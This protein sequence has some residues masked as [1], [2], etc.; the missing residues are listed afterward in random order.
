VKILLVD[1]DA[2]TLDV[3]TYSLRKNGYDVVTSTDGQQAIARWDR[4]KPDLVVL[5]VNLPK[6]N[7]FEVCRKIR[8][9]ALTPV[10]MLTGRTD[11]E[12]VL[13]GFTVGADD[14]VT[15]PFSHRQLVARIR[16]VM[17]RVGERVP[18]EPAGQVKTTDMV[19]DLQ[20]HEVIRNGQAVRL[21]PLEFKMLYMLASN[22]GRVVSSQRL[23]E[24]AWGY[25]GGE[26][27]LLKTHV[28]HIRQ[29]L[30]LGEPGPTIESVPWVGYRLTK[31]G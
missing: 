20:A 25:D 26:P 16:A 28:C 4:E 14:Y 15:K 8:D 9:S 13:Q 11:E 17:N 10:I 19:L 18:A 23:V 12:H 31:G 6:A 3:T 27:S 1:D 21:T 2:D 5:D 29:K 7:G 24:Y 22:E 30:G